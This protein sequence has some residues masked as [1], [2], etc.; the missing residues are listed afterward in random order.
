MSDSSVLKLE[1]LERNPQEAFD[2][3]RSCSVLSYFPESFLD[4][5]S[6]FGETRMIQSGEVLLNE[7][8]LNAE[9][10][11][12]LSGS[13]DIFVDDKKVYSLDEM[14]EIF[15]EMSLLAEAP[16]T[17]RVVAQE[18]SCFLVF[19]HQEI[20][21]IV[22]QN[23]EEFGFVLYQ[24]FSKILTKRLADANQ[25]TQ[26]VERQNK[27][28]TRLSREIELI[29][30]ERFQELWGK[31]NMTY[32]HLEKIYQSDVC[33]LVEDL[34]TQGDELESSEI[35]ARVKKI[36]NGLGP[37]F[38]MYS[39]ERMMLQKRVLLAESDKKYQQMIATAMVGAG[40]S[41]KVVEGRDE[42]FQLLNKEPFDILLVSPQM[43]EI[44]ELA[45]SVNEKI[46]TVLMTTGQ[47]IDFVHYFKSHPYLSNIVS[48]HEN[49]R[50]FTLR[51]MFTTVGKLATSDLFGMEKYLNWGAEVKKLEVQNSVQRSEAIEE[52][53]KYF[54]SGGLRDSIISRCRGVAEE[55]LMNVI[56]DAPKDSDGQPK[57]NHMSRKNRVDLDN[58]EKGE[59]HFAS[60]GV[61]AAVSVQ[62]P[63]GALDR[64]T[65]IKYL[66]KK[67]EALD[68][69]DD[70]HKAGGGFGLHL[71]VEQADL[72]VFN[73]R[74]GV[75]TEV[76]ALF[77]IDRK[78]EKTFEQA[79][80]HL[81]Y[82]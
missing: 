75:K 14:G 62:D 74:E 32:D 76:I 52:M 15:G 46:K 42:A 27:E 82:D 60:D 13:V 36:Q 20:S 63:F 11:F 81:F 58:H 24:V 71:I 38:K 67:D 10:F 29:A 21:D 16:C 50:I 80:F 26:I 68:E 40:V 9:L 51:N 7:G 72:V 22:D 12:L 45:Y 54:L 78:A 34:E 64:E 3:I 77:N 79:T 47:T 2:D 28:L 31:G 41:L 61:M 17:A 55:M 53:E 35:E 6:T 39:R 18:D 37:I 19:N 1:W 73:V 25:Q 43:M 49:A 48:L 33:Q 23:K 66:K 57:Y 30:H 5:L 56:Y 8:D 44:A 65:L 69:I 59:F 70:G 4:I